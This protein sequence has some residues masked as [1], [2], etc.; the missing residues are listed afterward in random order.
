MQT[1]AGVGMRILARADRIVGQRSYLTLA[2]EIA[3]GHHEWFDG[4]GYPQ[5]V[6]GS[7]IPLSA[8]ITAV[9]DVYDAL[10]NA[11]PYKGPWPVEQARD[12]IVERASTQFDPVVVEAFLRV[13]EAPEWHTPFG[14]P[15]EGGSSRV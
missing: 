14:V 10:T 3:N 6:A 11:R 9:A 2:A 15:T 1:H 5:R 13:L 4:T 7:H 12:Y 8:R